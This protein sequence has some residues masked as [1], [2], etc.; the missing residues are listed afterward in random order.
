LTYFGTITMVL[1]IATI[2]M[3][4][5]CMRN[6]GKGLKPHVSSGSLARTLEEQYQMQTLSSSDYMRVQGS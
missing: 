4:S 2:V 3:A 5:A 1:T 6:F